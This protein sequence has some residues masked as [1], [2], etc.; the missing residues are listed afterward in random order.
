MSSRAKVFVSGAS[1]FIR[2]IA[3]FPTNDLVVLLLAE[4]FQKSQIPFIS[5][6]S[7]IW[8]SEIPKHLC[9]LR[10]CIEQINDVNIST[11]MQCI[12]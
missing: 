1:V 6:S 8:K 2:W 4:L 5:K 10:N 11:H 12:M 3:Y 9:S 7:G